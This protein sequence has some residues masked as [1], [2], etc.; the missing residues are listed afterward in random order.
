MEEA[1][2]SLYASR[3]INSVLNAF[4]SYTAIMLNILTIHA[5]RKTSSLPKTLKT[6]LLSLAVSD[7]GV[8]L[9]VQPFHVALL[10]KDLQPDTS[11]NLLYD[12]ASKADISIGR[13]LLYASFLSVTAL[14]V[15]RFLAVHLHLRYQEL[16]TRMRV[17][18]AVITIWV[19]SA[20]LS[21][22]RF[23]WPE[24]GIVSA[25]ILGFCFISLTVFYCKMYF[26]V[27]RH[28]NQIQVLQVQQVTHDCEMAVNAAKLRKSAVS[29]FYV[30][31]V[32]LFCYFP[33]Y[34]VFVA[35][36]S[37]SKRNAT[38][39]LFNMYTLTLVHLNSSLNPAVYCWKMRQVRHAIMDILRNIFLRQD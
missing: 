10:V 13:L 9:L 18:A 37:I 35:Y 6:L 23:F 33:Q 16:V 28:A 17:V 3:I 24:M 39:M 38:L 11:D 15:D 31:L 29:T 12:F 20:F 32:F 30:Y 4:S 2:N 14:S 22:M 7:L 25:F 36:M 21:V 5:M 27:R 26:T 34:C 1:G 19:L 8:G